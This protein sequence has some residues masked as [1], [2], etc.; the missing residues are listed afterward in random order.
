MIK[1]KK[2]L[3][4]FEENEKYAEKVPLHDA[5][6]DHRPYDLNRSQALPA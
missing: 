6:N 3:D 2:R 5:M 4:Y 1:Q